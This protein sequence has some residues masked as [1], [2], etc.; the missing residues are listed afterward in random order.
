MFIF[1]MTIVIQAQ[2]RVSL[3]KNSSSATCLFIENSNLATYLLQHTYSKE[4]FLLCIKKQK[5][6]GT[7]KRVQRGPVRMIFFN[8]S[9]VKFELKV[10]HYTFELLRLIKH[11]IKHLVG[12]KS[13]PTKSRATFSLK[14]AAT[15]K[16]QSL[17][18][19]KKGLISQ[20][21]SE[22]KTIHWITSKWPSIITLVQRESCSYK[23]KQWLMRVGVKKYII[24]HVIIWFSISF[25]Q[26]NHHQVV[27][28][29]QAAELR[30]RKAH[31]HLPAK[32]TNLGQ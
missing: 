6:V 26:L 12:K 2:Q 27:I 25:R 17:K 18:H 31:L 9:D 7:C 21:Y 5:I 13:K 4:C 14:F 20:S 30:V 24:I 28:I 23:K 3:L 22:T 15:F 11:F 32:K 8:Q 16:I 1:F 10:G 29:S 19:T